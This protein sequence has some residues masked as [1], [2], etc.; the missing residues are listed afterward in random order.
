MNIPK[1][2]TI[3]L[4][5]R[6]NRACR[7]C[8]RHKMTSP[9][10]D[11]SLTLLQRIVEQLPSNTIIVPFFRGEAVF[12]PQF[13]EA[14]QILNRFDEVQM[15]TNGDLLTDS[16]KEAVLKTC[17]F[18]SYSLHTSSLPDDLPEIA[19]FLDEARSKGLDTQVSILETEIPDG[20]KQTLVDSWLQHA[21]RFRIYVEHSKDGF[22]NVDSKYKKD[23][24]N[25]P[26]SKP[27]TDMVIYWDG[28]VVLCNHDWDNKEPVGD[29][30]HQ[31]IDDVWNGDEY[32]KIRENHTMGYRKQVN[33]C[34]DCDYWMLEY[35]PERMFGEVYS[36]E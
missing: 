2:V 25:K 20:G 7:G 14:L 28:K 10:G 8:P 24:G 16:K 35:M 9:L 13:V 4:T 31:Y 32:S 11:M 6:C 12:H 19:E 36:N 21:D 27:F 1:R 17:S 34:K 15:A 3:E 5:N 30:N 29:L 33:S 22:G 18:I 26:C 23:F